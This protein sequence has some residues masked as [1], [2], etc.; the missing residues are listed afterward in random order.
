MKRL[1]TVALTFFSLCLFSQEA[2]NIKVTTTDE[3]MI[4][5]YDINSSPNNVFTVDMYFTKEDGSIL[6]PKSI[7]GDFGRVTGGRGK[8]IIWNVYEDVDGLSGSLNPVVNVMPYISNGKKNKAQDA[9]EPPA[10]KKNNGKIVD[11]ITDKLQKNKKPYRIGLLLGFGRSEVDADISQARFN[12]NKSFEA[13]AYF[14]Y[15]VHRRVHV[16]PEIIYHQHYF[17]ELIN[18]S[19]KIN[20]RRNFVRPQLVAGFAPIGAGLYF[21]AGIY[22]GYMFTSNRYNDQDLNV[23]N[24]TNFEDIIP[25]GLEELPFDK[26]DLGWIIGGSISFGQGNFVLGVRYTRGFD[27]F[28]ESPYLDIEG[29]PTNQRLRNNSTHFILQKSF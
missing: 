27:N 15:N 28:V 22:Y 19:D 13:G 6:E 9:P 4:I 8:A 16:Q 20:F 2:T 25:E 24:S 26:H 12:K 10:P 3:Q 14:R 17:G 21:N 23:T 5:T 1:T 11:I 18:G 7:N 29:A